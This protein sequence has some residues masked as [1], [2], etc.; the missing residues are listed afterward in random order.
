MGRNG[1]MR[2]HKLRKEKKNMS[3]KKYE[4]M[5]YEEKAE[6]LMNRIQKDMHTLEDLIPEMEYG[7]FLDDLAF[8]SNAFL[9]HWLG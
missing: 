4:E 3:R 2:Y 8:N 9:G 1:V 6:F 7:E 5:T